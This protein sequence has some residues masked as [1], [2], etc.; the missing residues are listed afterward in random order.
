MFARDLQG[1]GAVYRRNDR[2][3]QSAAELQSLGH[4]P[5]FF[6]LQHASG[7]AS[8]SGGSTRAFCAQSE[9]YRH[10]CGDGSLLMNLGT[11][12]TLA[13]IS[14]SEYLIEIVF[15]N[16]SLAVRR[17]ISHGNFH[18]HGS[19]GNFARLGNLAKQHRAH[20]RRIQRGVF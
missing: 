2:A 18:G 11:L 19:R 8:S 3:L 9:S 1:F 17:R 4:R 16:E 13:Q 7:L 12:S 20:H 15:D 14:S 6:Y 10:R 5:N